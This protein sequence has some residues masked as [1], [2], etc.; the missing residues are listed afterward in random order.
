MHSSF[1]QTLLPALLALLALLDVLASIYPL[2]RCRVHSRARALSG[3]LFCGVNKEHSAAT[4]STGCCNSCNR[5]FIE[6]EERGDVRGE[7]AVQFRNLHFAMHDV[8]SRAYVHRRLGRLHAYPYEHAYVNCCNSS[9]R[10]CNGLLQQLRPQLQRTAATAQAA[11]ETG[12][13]T[14]TSTHM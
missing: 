8:V 6:L 11:L 12:M 14:Y 10:S 5:A 2:P 7:F 3:M 13:H 1:L 4:A 9:G